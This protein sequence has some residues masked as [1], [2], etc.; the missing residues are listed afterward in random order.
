MH[1]PLQAWVFGAL[2]DEDSAALYWTFAFIYTLPYLA[3]GLQLDG[4]AAAALAAGAAHL[5]VE[6]VAQTEPAEV[7][8]PAVARAALRRLPGAVAV[9]AR[10][11][12]RVGGEVAGRARRAGGAAAR[13]PDRKFLEERSREARAELEEFDRR[14]RQRQREGRGD[15]D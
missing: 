5:Q 8:L 13:R 11:G 10:Y 7:E 12:A 14:Q 2:D 9:A 6:R 3:S 4:F 15:G 1:P